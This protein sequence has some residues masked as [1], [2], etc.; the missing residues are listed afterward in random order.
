[1]QN[2]GTVFW[3]VMAIVALAVAAFVVW[4]ISDWRQDRKI[5]RQIKK[6]K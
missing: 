2:E 6:N 4:L 1:M 3:V 5:M